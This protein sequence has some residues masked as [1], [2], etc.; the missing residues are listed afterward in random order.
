MGRQEVRE[1]W[2]AKKADPAVPGAEGDADGFRDGVGHPLGREPHLEAAA[3]DHVAV[4]GVLGADPGL[5]AAAGGRVGAAHREPDDPEPSHLELVGERWSLLIIRDAMF[6][7]RRHFR[8]FLTRS[9]ERISSNIL[10]DRLKTLDG[11][12]R[13][14]MEKIAC[15]T[16]TRCI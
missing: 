4:L 13:S 11:I 15:R 6:G 9:E 8:E 2:E 12:L 7:N 1:D 5:D 10:A 14:S 16:N 3:V